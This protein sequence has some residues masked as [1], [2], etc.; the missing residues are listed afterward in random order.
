MAKYFHHFNKIPTPSGDLSAQTCQ[1]FYFYQEFKNYLV[2]LFVKN[3][4]ELL[5]DAAEILADNN[6]AVPGTA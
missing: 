3:S 6:S 1:F 4:Y 2:C 5:P